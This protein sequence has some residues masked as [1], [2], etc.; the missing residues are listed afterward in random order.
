MTA[1]A[2]GEAAGHGA[3]PG[4]AA[5][6][7]AVEQ[8]EVQDEARRHTGAAAESKW[9]QRNARQGAAIGRDGVLRE[10]CQRV[11]R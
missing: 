3:A 1:G 6:T 9:P 8:Q 7:T 5:A 4:G 11:L 2:A 10:G